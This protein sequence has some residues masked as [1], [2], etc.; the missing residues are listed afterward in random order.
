MSTLPKSGM[1]GCGCCNCCVL[2]VVNHFP[3]HYELTRK[4][5]NAVV[6]RWWCR[7]AS[8]CH[9]I[10]MN[11]SWIKGDSMEFGVNIHSGTV[12]THDSWGCSRPN[13]DLMARNI[14]RYR[15]ERERQD[16]AQRAV[17][18]TRN[19]WVYIVLYICIYICHEM[20]M[21]FLL[22]G[23][24]IYIYIFMYILEPRCPYIQKIFAYH[25]FI[26]FHRTPDLGLD[27]LLS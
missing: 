14:K 6:L 27:I 16:M 5:Q 12:K 13:E 7:F 24:N 17:K 4:D 11:I 10:L 21:A 25:V 1:I 22:F 3:N 2:Q 9:R 18:K 8:K 15:R 23:Q 26:C 20:F 19:Q